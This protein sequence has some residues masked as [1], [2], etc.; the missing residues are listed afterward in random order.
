MEFVREAMRIERGND[1]ESKCF[2][3]GL[4]LT[5]VESLGGLYLLFIDDL[6]HLDM[7][8]LLFHILAGFPFVFP[9]IMFWRRHRRYAPIVERSCYNW[10][11]WSCVVSMLFALISGIW[12]TFRG[13]SGIYWLWLSH[14]VISLY[15]FAALGLY[16]FLTVKLWMGE[17]VGKPKAQAF[18]GRTLWKIGA[19]VA[20]GSVVLVAANIAYA[21]FYEEPP[22]DRVV[23]GYS[24]SF[25]DD[26]FYPSRVQTASGGFYEPVH[27][28]RSETCGISGCH[29]ETLVQFKDSVHYRT[30]TPIFG[31]V[32]SLFM[33][34]ARQGQFLGSRGSLQIDEMRDIHEGRESFRF[35]AG[36]H[37]PVALIAGEIDRGAGLPSFEEWEGDSCILCHRIASMG[38]VVGGGGGDYSVAPPPNR[39]LFAFSDHPVGRWLNKTLI[40]NK[41]EHHMAMFDTPF[42][43]TSE[44]CVGCHKRLQ[45]SYWEASPY[46]HP[47]PGEET[48]EC[49]DCHMPQV[50]THN[51]VSALEKGTIS[52]HRTLAANLVTPMLYG[53]EEQD[54]LTREFMKNDNMVLDVVAPAEIQPHD[55]LEFI[56][57]VIN[58]GVGHIFPAG[59]EADLIE[60]WTEVTVTDGSGEQLLSYGLLDENG[61][62][63]HDSTYVYTVMPH[64]QDGR[65]LEL[66][67]HRN[68][69]FS[70]DKL[71]VVPAKYYDEFPFAVD[72][73]ESD[74]IGPIKIDARLRFRKFNQAFLDFA[75]EAGF[76]PRLEAPV[77]ELDVVSANVEFTDDPVVAERAAGEWLAK[78]D[79]SDDIDLAAYTKKPNFDDHLLATKLSL[80]SRIRLVDAQ[81]LYAK[82]RYESAL[83]ILDELSDRDVQE[84]MW[85]ARLRSALVEAVQE[86]RE[87]PVGDVVDPFGGGDSG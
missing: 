57:R 77:V 67:R 78:L 34:E 54:R 30:P 6:T 38:D 86:R 37:T 32:Q 27:F 62:L 43:E 25:G 19:K 7:T 44:Y 1:W 82:G 14:T 75:A 66:D 33:E 16:I 28:L 17:M 63:D 87:Q 23:E 56:V 70:E 68:W 10:L 20:V 18:L 4:A 40:N 3:L 31:A 58:K 52:D 72:L 22:V 13:I 9:C 45:F 24:Y 59:P 41:P 49:Q 85:L 36:C 80:E 84:R 11:G 12:L 83:A 71:H 15:G 8:L 60:S 74:V 53:L 29:V 46:N 47:P 79:G 21:A 64:D 65:A 26:P 35:C 81:A 2:W 76:A 39:Y 48:K 42:Y 69:M 61:H 5:V 73:A 50:A 51:D 55:R